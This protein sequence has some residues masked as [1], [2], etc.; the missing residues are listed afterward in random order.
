MRRD[1]MRWIDWLIG[2][3]CRVVVHHGTNGIGNSRVRTNGMLRG[4][5]EGHG[6]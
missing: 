3:H 2:F 6:R 5:T 4:R 1:E